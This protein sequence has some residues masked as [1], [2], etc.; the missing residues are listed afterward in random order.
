[1]NLFFFFSGG[2]LSLN[3]IHLCIFFWSQGS[4]GRLH[5]QGLSAFCYRDGRWKRKWVVNTRK[6]PVPCRISG[7]HSFVVCNPIPRLKSNL[8]ISSH[9]HVGMTGRICFTQGTEQAFVAFKWPY[10]LC[11]AQQTPTMLKH[12]V[13]ICVHPWDSLLWRHNDFTS[14]ECGP[15]NNFFNSI[16]TIH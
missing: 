5:Q 3:F 8:F 13:H 11:S 10:T 15:L 12:S 9:I 7:L 1:M 14:L 2:F 4:S 16:L 6:L